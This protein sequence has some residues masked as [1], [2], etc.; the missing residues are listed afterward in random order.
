MRSL[1][2]CPVEGQPELADLDF[3]AG[4]KDV[5]VDPLPVDVRAVER[6]G[7]PD[8]EG[9]ALADELRVL[10]RNRGVVEEDVE[11]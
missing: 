11:R 4:L 9:S 5:G 10:A 2:V 7:V 6:T 1:G 3:V 8:E